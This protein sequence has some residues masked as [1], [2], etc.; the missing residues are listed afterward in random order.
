MNGEYLDINE[1]GCSV[2]THTCTCTY[3][4]IVCTCIYIYIQS[5]Q[6][7]KDQRHFL[8]FYDILCQTPIDNRSGAAL[9]YKFG[10]NCM[11]III[12][13]YMKSTSLIF[14]IASYKNLKCGQ[15][16]MKFCLVSNDLLYMY[17]HVYT[18]HNTFA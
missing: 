17:V 15:A 1:D 14:Y 16:L 18:S 13:I 8:W 7:A 2:P 6:L 5:F 10:K 3:T 11:T 4:Y 12:N 9:L